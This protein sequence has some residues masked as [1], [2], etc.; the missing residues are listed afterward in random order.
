MCRECVASARELYPELSENERRELLWE[1]TSFPFGSPQEVRNQLASLGTRSVHDI[2][3][4]NLK[5][6]SGAD[7]ES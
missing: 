4:E 3:Y 1:H 2:A 7:H 6:K 5:N